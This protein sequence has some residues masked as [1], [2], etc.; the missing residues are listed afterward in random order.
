[1]CLTEGMRLA[2]ARCVIVVGSCQSVKSVDVDE[3]E[4]VG[5][6]E[7]GDPLPD[8]SPW[9]RS[10]TAPPSRSEALGRWRGGTAVPPPSARRRTVRTTATTGSGRG[11]GSGARWGATRTG[12]ERSGSVGS[13]NKS[14]AMKRGDEMGG[15]SRCSSSYSGIY[16]DYGEWWS[17][18][19]PFPQSP[20]TGPIPFS[21]PCSRAP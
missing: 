9:H 1:M 11:S 4:D 6:D 15:G 20:Q 10:P 18:H 5:R 3:G 8:A 2:G 7:C 19:D 14:G 21:S 13:D 17:L 16:S 12:Q